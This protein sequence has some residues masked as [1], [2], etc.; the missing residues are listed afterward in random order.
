MGMKMDDF[1]DEYDA[2][3][4]AEE[5]RL[6]DVKDRVINILDNIIKVLVLVAL[7]AFIWA[8]LQ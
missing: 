3:R 4:E 6:Q 2:E 8:G 7:G 5:Q 1:W